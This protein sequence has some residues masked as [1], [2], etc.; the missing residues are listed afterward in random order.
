MS[1]V[2]SEQYTISPY[3][4]IFP[5]YVG[6]VGV[7]ILTYQRRVMEHAGYNSWVSLI[8]TGLSMHLLL[9]MLY[10][11]LSS[12]EDSRDIVAI[13]HKLFGKWLGNLINLAIV[14]YFVLGAFVKF[15]VYV[16]M[17]QVWL[18]P[19]M[20]FLPVSIVILLIVYYAVSGGLRSVT[21]IAVWATMISCLSIVPQVS[22]TFPYLHPMNLLPLFNHSATD[23]LLSS[24]DMGFEYLG[25]E[26]LLFIYPFVKTPEKSQKWAH[27]I[28]ILVTL[29]YL[30]ILILAFMFFTEEQLLH[31]IWPTLN[32]IG[33]FEVPLLQR[34]EYMA[35]S[36]WF[37]KIIAGISIFI[38]AACRG[39]KL[40]FH[41]RPRISLIVFL[42]AITVSSYF[43]IDHRTVEW[44]SKMYANVGLYFIYAYIPFIFLC[45]MVRKR[46]ASRATP[47]N[48]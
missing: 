12:I 27:L 39:M 31:T 47:A 24:K 26:T 29:L 15:K 41:F 11:I 33:I 36:L 45:V 2:T 37:I 32:M 10:K 8:I 28:M 19:S 23:I 13:N 21:G 35:V 17:I 44:V 20:N 18:F 1:Q 4:I 9:W 30:M 7:G 48:E 42:A 25:F 43:I 16:E 34:L 46:L 22:L 3:L 38:W 5:L 14:L 40:A 6:M